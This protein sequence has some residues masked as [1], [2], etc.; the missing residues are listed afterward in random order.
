MSRD[1]NRFP[2]AARGAYQRPVPRLQ[3][4]PVAGPVRE[5]AQQSSVALPI[6]AADEPLVAT[7][8]VTSVEPPPV[9]APPVV[10]P[11]AGEAVSPVATSTVSLEGFVAPKPKASA[12]SVAASRPDPQL[13]PAEAIEPSVPDMVPAVDV[14]APARTSS[15]QLSPVEIDSA[16]ASGLGRRA[17][18]T[19]KGML[20]HIMQ[21]VG[22]GALAVVAVFFCWLVYDTW[23]EIYEKP[24]EA[25]GSSSYHQR[26]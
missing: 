17:Q 12:A 5:V 20:A 25:V 19:Q 16:H 7:P 13:E 18:S 3:R 8:P 22:S 23:R 26:G 21:G 9:P 4:M 1:E 11:P 14:Q 2:Y 6:Q 15:L 24:D 10:A